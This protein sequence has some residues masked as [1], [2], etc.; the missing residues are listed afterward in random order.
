[1]QRMQTETDSPQ[2]L[3]GHARDFYR[4]LTMRVSDKR[5]DL[6]GKLANAVT[7]ATSREFDQDRDSTWEEAA[8]RV[9]WRYMERN[10]KVRAAYRAAVAEFNGDRKR[11]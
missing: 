3:D 11:W 8:A 2:R 6:V 7:E 5:Q 10:P 9:L 1:M 4:W